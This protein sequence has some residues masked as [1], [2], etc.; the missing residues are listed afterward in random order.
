VRRRRRTP[1]QA[2]P[3]WS[4]S[5]EGLSPAG[6]ARKGAPSWFF[7]GRFFTGAGAAAST[8]RVR[9]HQ[10]R[11]R[12]A[13]PGPGCSAGWTSSSTGPTGS[14]PRRAQPWCLA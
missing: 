5:G 9:G 1:G 2:N 6:S 10:L 13:D 12:R 11:H 14:A 3:A 4:G 8:R 7:A